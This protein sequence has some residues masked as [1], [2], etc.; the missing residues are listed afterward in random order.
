VRL[1]RNNR[2]QLLVIS[3]LLMAVLSL[4]LAL[5]VYSTGLYRQQLRYEPVKE[6]VLG[7]TNDLDRA[8]AQALRRASLKYYE[9]G[10]EE[11][12]A[13]EGN[14]FISR[15]IRSALSASVYLG[16]RISVSPAE[17][18]L[19]DVWFLFSWG[20]GVGLSYAYCKFALDI[21]AFGFKGWAGYYGK[22]VRL[23]ISGEPTATEDRTKGLDIILVIDRGGSMNQ[24]EPGDPYT[25]MY[26]VKEAVKAFVD[27][28]NMSRIRVG[29]VSYAT[30]ATLDAPLTNNSETVKSAIDALYVHDWPD[31]WTNIGGGIDRS[32]DEFEANGR[33]DSDWVMI[34]MSDGVA[35]IDSQGKYSPARGRDYALVAAERARSLRIDSYTIGVGDVYRQG[36]EKKQH[37][38]SAFDEDLLKDIQTSGYYHAPSP[39]DLRDIYRMIA[40]S[41]RSGATTMCFNVVSEAG[42]LVSN[43]IPDSMEIYVRVI[44]DIWVPARIEDLEYLGGGNYTVRFSPKINPY[45]LGVA[46]YVS[47]PEDQI[48]VCAAYQSQELVHVNLSSEEETGNSTNLGQIQLGNSVFSLPN[49]TDIPPG[50]YYLQYTPRAGYAFLN[51]TTGSATVEQPYEAPVSITIADDENITAFYRA[52]GGTEPTPPRTVDLSLDSEDWSGLSS[53]LGQIRLNGTVY[54]LPQDG[55]DLNTGRY[56]IEYVSQNESYRFLWWDVLWGDVIVWNS[57]GSPTTLWVNGSGEVRAAYA[58]TPATAQRRPRG[59]WAILFADS[60]RLLPFP[61]WSGDDGTLY[62]SQGEGNARTIVLNSS[63]SPEI[64]LARHVNMTAFIRPIPASSAKNITMELGFTYDGQFYKIGS[65][66]H[67][68]NQQGIYLLT[69]DS[70]LGEYPL[71]MG[72][73]PQGSIITLNVTLTFHDLGGTFLLYYGNDKPS[74]VRLYDTPSVWGYPD[75][76]VRIASSTQNY[77]FVTGGGMRTRVFRDAKGSWWAFIWD[78]DSYDYWRSPDGWRWERSGT[79]TSNGGQD[80]APLDVWFDDDDPQGLHRVYTV[81]GTNGMWHQRG[82][83]VDNA[84]IWDAERTLIGSGGPVKLSSG[85]TR[86]YEGGV[87]RCRVLSQTDGGNSMEL[88]SSDDDGVTW[89]V[90]GGGSYEQIDDPNVLHGIWRLKPSAYNY[91]SVIRRHAGHGYDLRYV[92]SDKVAYQNNLYDDATD[93]TD[94]RAGVSIVRF[95][96]SNPKYGHV[97]F[98]NATGHLLYQRYNCDADNWTNPEVLDSEASYPAITVDGDGN[99]YAYYV[100]DGKVKS[101]VYERTQGLWHPSFEPFGSSFSSPRWLTCAKRDYDN[102]IAVMWAEAESTDV[103]I[104]FADR[105]DFGPQ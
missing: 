22:F 72:L 75:R 91:F 46:V 21:D 62:P 26:Y 70:S 52:D 16:S 40:K 41:L 67:S 77:M 81:Y 85:I 80:Y 12:A 98:C 90:T 73:I 87:G 82:T 30:S 3:A 45:T 86:Y 94:P 103:Y 53:S 63:P 25:K 7:I 104:G 64:R 101:R 84:I 47:T 56:E 89:A 37:K 29:I 36:T 57:A 33:P 59:D 4:S 8:L 50:T 100:K 20:R 14:N 24:S 11:A 39:K 68:V 58:F 17:D 66:V 74:C 5:S 55:I 97:L 44:G 105:G 88:F 95:D 83:I 102:K 31:I 18:G 43:L 99:L 42:R 13:L 27:L 93:V 61:L 32:S 71:D 34:L 69:V 49:S 28:L 96:Y 19:S 65:G 6:T 48:R 1:A 60:A 51:W 35:N 78:G 2:G 9:T 23:E 92:K 10:S 76:K 79:L 15:W 54:N 38:W